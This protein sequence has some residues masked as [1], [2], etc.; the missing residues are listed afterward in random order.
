MNQIE[1][2]GG[3]NAI[4]WLSTLM[5]ETKEN[6][7]FAPIY[8]EN[9]SLNEILGTAKDLQNT[10]SLISNPNFRNNATNLLELASYTQQTSRL[11]KL[12]DFRTK[13]GESDFSERL[14]EFKNKRFSDP[15]PG[16]VFVKYYNITNTKITFGFK[17]LG[18][19]ALFLEVMA[20][21]MA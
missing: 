6:P 11:T 18:E 2:V 7:L 8:L 19:R 16:E 15:N 14:L 9:H 10:A 13:E 17:G 5:M 4:K 21:F 3:N 20:R 12:S 1:A